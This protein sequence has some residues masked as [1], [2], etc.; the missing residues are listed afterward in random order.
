MHAQLDLEN[1]RSVLIRQEETL[2][3]AL[4]ERAQFKINTII[5]RPGG[6]PIPRFDGSFVEYLLHGTEALHA[7]VRRYTSPDEHAF[8]K[9]LP[10]PIL[11]LLSAPWPIAATTVNIN[12]RIWR[13]YQDEIIPAICAAGDDEQYGSS[14]VCDVA[15][16]QALSKRIHYGKFVA[17]SKYCMQRAAFEPLLRAGDIAGVRALITDDAVE[18][19]LLKRVARKAATYGQE[20]DADGENP[21]F[22]IPP[23]LIAA[24]YRDWIIPLTKD[25]E[26]AYLL[27]R[28]RAAQAP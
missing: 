8:C 19:R 10:A 27:E 18:A 23:A 12:D 13:I 5:Y 16:L 28:V 6:I 11:P 2:I 22:K 4:V 7:T 3:F 25:V 21:V 15:C 14:A 17:E 1:I 26:I 9:N 24:L 20:I